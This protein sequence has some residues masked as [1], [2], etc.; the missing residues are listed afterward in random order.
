MVINWEVNI[1]TAIAVLTAAGI[2]A[3][4]YFG[5]RNDLKNLTTTVEKG[6]DRL[7]KNIEAMNKVVMDMALSTQRQDNFD[8]RLKMLV[9][10]L[11]DLKHGKG[12]V[13]D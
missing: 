5:N 3:E 13:K 6:M 10:D 11:R 7:D 2:L 9:Q 12:F 8:D 1:T 4:R